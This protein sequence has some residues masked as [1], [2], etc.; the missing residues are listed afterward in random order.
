MSTTN[1]EPENP[2]VTGPEQLPVTARSGE[3]LLDR[4]MR[5]GDTA[6][7][8]VDTLVSMLEK[9]RKASIRATY[10]SDWIIHTSTDHDGQVISQ[11]G[12]LQDIGA[13]R[14]GKVWGCELTAPAIERE[15][16]PDGTYSYHLI[17]EAYSKITGERV[18]YVEGSRWSGDPFFSRSKGP[19]EKI[20]P[21]DV[22]KSAYANLH[23]RAVRSLAG[24]GGVPLEVLRDCGIN[25]E[26]VVHV[27]YAK[28]AKGGDSVGARVGSDGGGSGP[29][30]NFGRSKGKRIS[31]LTDKDLAWYTTAVS[32]SIADPAK[33]AYKDRNESLLAALKQESD[34]R[35][36][37]PVT[38]SDGSP[39]PSTA[40]PPPA[41][42]TRA[43]RQTAL[44]KRLSAL[45]GTTAGTILKHLVA[46]DS[47]AALTDDELASVEAKTDEELK[48]AAMEVIERTE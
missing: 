28:G 8:K 9:L 10:P 15:D 48:D 2:D 26:K 35:Q 25:I 37:S 32:D 27:S 13:E 45:K 23:G 47:L 5:E 1:V 31:E 14:A 21:T 6:M 19:D 3:A 7:E 18:E 24:L 46:K 4:W 39:S 43:Q 12:Y 42:L 44:F 40:S 20:D 11:R 30:L 36:L 17:A 33:L 41:S 22:R 38:A 29:V 34:R 16:F